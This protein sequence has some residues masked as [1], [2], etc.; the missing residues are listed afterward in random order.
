MLRAEGLDRLYAQTLPTR[1]L[2]PDFIAPQHQDTY[3]RVCRALGLQPASTAFSLLRTLRTARRQA[4]LALS[5]KIAARLDLL[6]DLPDLLRDEGAV[7]LRD[8][9]LEGVALLV[10][11]TVSGA[12][13]DVPTWRLGMVL[14]T[15]GHTW[16]P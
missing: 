9:G 2:H 8:S 11:R 4:G 1:M 13:A 10:V 3:L 16:H 6:P 15:G 7:V 12:P 5:A 14:D